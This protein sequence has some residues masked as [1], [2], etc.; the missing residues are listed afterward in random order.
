MTRTSNAIRRRARSGG[1]AFIGWVIPGIPRRPLLDAPRVEHLYG[2]QRDSVP[3]ATRSR[4]STWGSRSRRGLLIESPAPERGVPH[5]RD[6][7]RLGHDHR[8]NGREILEVSRAHRRRTSSSRTPRAMVGR[9]VP[10][11]PEH[12]GSSSV[13]RAAGAGGSPAFHRDCRL[14]AKTPRNTSDLGPNLLALFSEAIGESTSG[15]RGCRQLLRITRA[16]FGPGPAPAAIP[17]RG[18]RPAMLIRE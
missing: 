3:L 17:G 18:A 16:T 10:K 9:L 1:S 15:R 11:Y 5:A 2:S 8:G 12:D 13:R 4:C 7:R 6:A 14:S